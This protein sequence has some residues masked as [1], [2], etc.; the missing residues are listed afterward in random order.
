LIRL[1]ALADA[2]SVAAIYNHYILHTAVTFEEQVISA[3][4]M[5]AR[6]AEVISTSLPWLVLEQD[7]CA[8]GYAYAAR[9]KGRSAYRFSVESTIY[10]APGKVGRGFGTALYRALMAE[11][12]QKGLHAVIGGITLPNPASVALHERF[13]L[14]KAGEFREVG[15]KFGRWVDVGYWQAVL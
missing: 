14:R 13:G 4:E 3:D 7:G 10:L 15:R 12:K 6:I 8:A 2:E 11:L 5:S 9:W 1:A